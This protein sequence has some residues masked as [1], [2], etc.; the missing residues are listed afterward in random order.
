[1]SS[2]HID[3]SIRHVSGKHWRFT[4]LYGWSDNG[5]KNK[6]WDSIKSLG[7]ES[8]KAWM[9]GGDFNEML[10]VHEKSGGN[11]C[12]FASIKAFRDSLGCFNLRDVCYKG[13]PFTWSN[14]RHE[15]FIDESFN[16]VVANAVWHDL[17]R[18]ATTKTIIWDSS[19]H[20]SLCISF[21]ESQDSN[22]RKKLFYKKIFRFEARWLHVD[23]F[24][25]I[26][27]DGK[28]VSWMRKIEHCG[29]LLMTWDKEM[30][31]RTQW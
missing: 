27:K 15:G 12:D 16:R 5:N 10:F 21:G 31:K 7:G 23:K 28:G 13:Y 19:D 30:F 24:D 2:R 8:N 17:F 25:E 20:Y 3:V 9:I 22:D 29:K 6:T 11:P 26:I 1:M 14:G 4:G 18:D